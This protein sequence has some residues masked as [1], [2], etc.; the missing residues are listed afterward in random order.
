MLSQK[1]RCT[2][3]SVSVC[4]KKRY[5]CEQRR[6]TEQSIWALLAIAEIHEREFEALREANKELGEAS[7]ELGEASN[8]FREAGRATDERLNVLI[9]IV[10]RHISEGHKH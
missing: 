8:E 10:E 3:T 9:N 4:S 6:S 7:N 5:R 1:Q 2:L